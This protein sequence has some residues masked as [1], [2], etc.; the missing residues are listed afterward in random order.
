[1][2]LRINHNIA[3]LMAQKNVNR[4]SGAMEQSYARLS[5]GLR[6]TRAADDAAGL[7]VSE[8]LRADI[9]S[10]QV[11]MR[12]TND[13]VSVVQIAEGALSEVHSI[14]TRMRELAMQSASGT[15]GDDERAYLQT[16]MDAIRS[17]IDRLAN[18]TEFNGVNLLT[19]ATT[20]DVQV[21]IHAGSN[22]EISITLA[23]MD[24]NA[25]D[26][27]GGNVSVANASDAS[28]A[29]AYIDTAIGSVS[30]HRATL[31]AQQNRLLH[32]FRN[33]EVNLENM[34]AAESQIRDVDFASETAEL[35]KNQ[36]LAQAGVSVLAQANFAPQ[37]ALTLLG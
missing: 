4:S 33:L 16:E 27:T 15:L 1:M 17:E 14:L 13:G 9:A 7:G 23:S 2:S 10:T 19:S 35:T 24:V 5:S 36:I 22:Y 26:I 3:S 12:N 29:L 18:V 30:S 25:L 37:M 20:M 32:T 21:G 31:G 6:I 8:N 34:T 11:A 28:A